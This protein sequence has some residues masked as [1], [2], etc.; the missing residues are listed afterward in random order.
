MSPDSVSMS[1]SIEW[2]LLAL[3]GNVIC[4]RPADVH[5]LFSRLVSR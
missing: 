5:L 3:T 1:I 2:V 4:L